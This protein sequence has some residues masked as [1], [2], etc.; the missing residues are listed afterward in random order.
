MDKVSN[1]G[2]SLLANSLFDYTHSKDLNISK[3]NI[4]TLWHWKV[5]YLISFQ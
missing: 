1:S 2:I 4:A 3:L 5:L